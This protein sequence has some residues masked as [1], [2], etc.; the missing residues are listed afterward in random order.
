MTLTVGIVGS[1]T[2]SL[3]AEPLKQALVRRDLP[4]EV[5]A[6][7]YGQFR[8]ELADP[9]AVGLAADVIVA[10]TAVENFE[11]ELPVAGDAED[12]SS[13][14]KAAAR[15]VANWLEIAKKAVPA[16]TLIAANWCWLRPWR[17]GNEASQ[18]VVDGFNGE[19]AAWQ[20]R[21]VGAHIANIQGAFQRLGTDRVADPRMPVLAGTPLGRAGI[22]AWADTI[23]RTIAATRRPRAKVIVTDC[24]NT[25]WGGIVGEDGVENLLLGD[26]GAGRPYYAYQREL[27]RLK[28]AGFLLAI[29]SKNNRADVLSVFDSRQDMAL[30]LD[31][32]VE[33][34]IDWRNKVDHIA[35][36]ADSL[37]LGVDSFVF[38]DDSP[39][40]LAQVAHMFPGVTTLQVPENGIALVEKLT[41]VELLDK[42][43]LSIEDRRKTEQ[44]RAR[45]Q[46]AALQSS[47]PD[48]S[49]YLKQLETVVTIAE[50]DGQEVSRVAQLTQKTNQFNLTT[51]RLTES[52]VEA[53]CGNSAWSILTLRVSDKFGD[54]GLT[55]VVISE[56]NGST[57]TIHNILMSCRVLGRGIED[58]LV[59]VACNHLVQ[60]GV[61]RIEG[62]Y[63]ETA[64]NSV[65]AEFYAR[66]SFT[67]AGEGRWT[68]DDSSPA[69]QLPEHIALKEIEHV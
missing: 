1:G 41:E 66:N 57:A 38:V 69:P 15:E 22:E 63:R 33:I 61:S 51:W 65:C 37:S 62:M 13:A 48:L 34:K 32:F 25:L 19:L 35:E 9:A 56:R 20:A 6:G 43:D 2:V 58:A 17:P 64:R 7:G 46:N 59:A 47:A 52:E 10:A 14:G 44:Y 4:A 5:R 12:M 24:D 42:L 16:A 67:A 29:S 28:E 8:Q 30:S 18:Y 27:L 50:C 49:T 68:W 40:E 21:Q 11:A 23:A 39:V 36:I 45:A 60:A 31:D 55:G 3:F 53:L 26:D 54:H